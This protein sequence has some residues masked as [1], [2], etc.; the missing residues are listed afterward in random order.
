MRVKLTFTESILGTW[1]NN[2]EVASEF[3][4]GKAPDA[5]TVEEEIAAIG[6]ADY[7]DKTMTVFPRVDGKPVFYN[8][9]IEG[10]FKEA[11]GMLGRVKTTKSSK[12]K[13]YKKVIDGLI[14]VKERTIPINFDGDLGTLQRPLRGQTAQGER[15]SL[16]NSE[17]IPAGA[18]IEFSILCLDEAHYP[19]VKE[20]LDYGKLKG[21][22]QWR[23]SGHG[24]F[25]WEL[26]EDSDGS[27][28][29]S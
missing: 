11:C 8:Y 25:T 28:S 17:E 27:A 16:A 14:F 10:F 23:N 19:L 15:I 21:I 18:T 5:K 29:Q 26:L 3:I 6:V 7:I 1:S 24:R 4:A 22:G 13:A 9:Q 20:W 12:L 2:P